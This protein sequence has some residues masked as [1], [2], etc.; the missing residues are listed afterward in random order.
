MQRKG[1][2]MINNMNLFHRGAVGIIHNTTNLDLV[3]LAHLLSLWNCVGHHN[4]FDVRLFDP[5]Q[6]RTRKNPMR[7]DGIDAGCTGLLQSTDHTKNIER[8]KL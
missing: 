6:C 2:R 4:G 1:N 5:S 8:D 7:D 3:T